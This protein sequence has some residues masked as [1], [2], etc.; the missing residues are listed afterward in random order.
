M[1]R[2][3]PLKPSQHLWLK[4]GSYINLAWVVSVWWNANDKLSILFANLTEPREW[5]KVTG[6]QIVNALKMY[7][8]AHK[9]Y[10]EAQ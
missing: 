7:H 9:M 4:T 2:L 3:P 5:G 10:H 8:E 1:D 6:E